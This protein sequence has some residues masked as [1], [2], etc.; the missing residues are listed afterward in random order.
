MLIL[1]EDI[2]FAFLAI[3]LGILPLITAYSLWTGKHWSYKA[4]IVTFV[5]LFFI[6]LY[7]L[8][9]EENVESPTILFLLS[10]YIAISYM[11][12]RYVYKNVIK[13]SNKRLW[14]QPH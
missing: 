11:I 13:S 5:M 12:I 3:L 2:L 8:L 10:G 1:G 6:A 14:C 9:V 4:L 7:G